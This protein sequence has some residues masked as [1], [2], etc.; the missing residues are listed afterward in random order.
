LEHTIIETTGLREPLRILQLTDLHLCECD[1]RNA[2]EMEAVAIRKSYF[3]EAVAHLEEA[4]E[5]GRT[6]PF[7]LLVITGDMVDSP[8]EANLDYLATQLQKLEKPWVMTFGNHDWSDLRDDLWQ[9]FSKLEIRAQWWQRF[10]NLFHQPFEIMSMRLNGVRLVFIDNSDYQI[11]AAQLEATRQ[12]LEGDEDC[13]F[14]M[15]IPMSNESLRPKT[16]QVWKESILMADQDLVGE[17]APN[18]WTLQF[19][20]LMATH[21]RARAIFSGHVHFDH[22]DAFGEKSYQFVTEACYKGGRRLIEVV[23]N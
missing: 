10:S 7:D 8:T 20:R 22:R 5:W 1:E 17:F 18:L 4:L 3:S 12:A 9:R 16:I 2:A 21:P 11:T 19:C 23:K 6:A 13:L 14:F 15:H